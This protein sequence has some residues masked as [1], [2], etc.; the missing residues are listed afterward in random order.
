MIDAGDLDSSRPRSRVGAMIRPRALGVPAVRHGQGET[1]AHSA[2]LIAFVTAVGAW[3]LDFHADQ[4]SGG[5]RNIQALFLGTYGLSTFVFLLLDQ[6]DRYRAPGLGLFVISGVLFLTVGPIS[7]LL[8]GQELSVII[9][10]SVGTLLY[11][12]VSYMTCR[13]VMVSDPGRVRR[14][15]AVLCLAFILLGVVVL[16]FNSGSIDFSSTRYEILS[17][18]TIPALGYIECMIL[19]GLSITEAAGVFSGTILV[20]LSVTRTYLISA[21][22]QFI[23]LL[24]GWRTLLLPRLPLVFAV[25]TIAAAGMVVFGG[26]EL[27]RWSDRIFAQRTR[28][29]EDYTYYTR[30]SEWDYMIG[31]FTRSNRTILFG[32]GIAARTIWYNPRE[33]GGGVALGSVGFG[34]GEHISLLF[35]GGLVGGGLLLVLQFVQAIQSFQLLARLALRPRENSDLLFLAGWGATI[36]LGAFAA[37]FFSSILG[38][39]SWALW[40]G[41]GTGL[42]LGARA[43]YLRAHETPS[44]ATAAARPKGRQLSGLRQPPGVPSAVARRRRALALPPR[45]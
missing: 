34:H 37:N 17:G 6:A 7:A 9:S 41:V 11:F 26:S 22:V 42:F 12:S 28:S 20:V 44:G 10:A 19:F 3:M 13:I 39:R 24:L 4:G 15:L 40:Y 36:I 38:N 43:R 45:P 5:A 35:I 8:N 30:K 1:S 25:G 27:D 23:A 18:A 14:A 32:N 29:G 2:L 31:A 33:I 21:L 16:R